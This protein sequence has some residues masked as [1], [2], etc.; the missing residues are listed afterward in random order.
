VILP[1]GDHRRS[2]GK[3]VESMVGDIIMPIIGG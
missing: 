1:S 2:L 3:L